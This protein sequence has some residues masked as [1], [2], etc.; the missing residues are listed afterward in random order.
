MRWIKG[1]DQPPPKKENLVMRRIDTKAVL[2]NVLVLAEG[3][4]YAGYMS[5]WVDVNDIEWLEE[6]EDE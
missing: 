1:A 5:N 2:A 6:E 3:I 4:I